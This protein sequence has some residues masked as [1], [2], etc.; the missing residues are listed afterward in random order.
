MGKS[1]SVITQFV[2]S[3]SWLHRIGGYANPTDSDLI[4]TILEGAKRLQGKPTTRKEPVS[5]EILKKIYKRMKS[6]G[7]RL[8][9]SHQRTITFMVLAFSGLLRCQEALH[10]KRNNIAFHSSYVALFLESSKTDKYRAGRT[11]LIARTGTSLDPVLQ[12]FKYL[13]A[14][15]IPHKSEQYIFRSIYTDKKTGMQ[16]LRPGNKPISYTTIKDV[17]KDELQAIGLDPKRYGTHSLRAGGAT[18]A[19]NQE[20]PDRLFKIHRRWRSDDSKDRYIK[21]SIDRR[22]HITLNLGL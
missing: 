11:V 15:R 3:A 2:A 7:A 5:P 16:S 8:S 4:R 1:I 19:A 12:L 9:L 10:I 6:K 13:K 17:L 21:D 20:V 22:L 14:A 18:A